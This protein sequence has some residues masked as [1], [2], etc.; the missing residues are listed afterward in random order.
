[1][2]LYFPRGALTAHGNLTPVL[3]H[4]IVSVNIVEGREISTLADFNLYID[5]PN[6]TLELQSCDSGEWCCREMN[7]PSCC[8]NEF[9]LD[10][11]SLLI[12]NTQGITQVVAP[13]IST[14]TRTQSNATMLVTVTSTPSKTTSSISSVDNSSSWTKIPGGSSSTATPLS[15]NPDKSIIIGVAIGV[16]LL[17]ALSAIVVLW[18]RV[19][20]YSTLNANRSVPAQNR[21]KI[22]GIAPIVELHSDTPLYELRGDEVDN[23]H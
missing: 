2:A 23:H 8:A 21:G 4:A 16:P 19:Q 22:G 11:G 3:R 14:L 13:T 18:C 6:S 15:G 7:S 12:R 9:S 17:V 10:I 20:H 1:M 5:G